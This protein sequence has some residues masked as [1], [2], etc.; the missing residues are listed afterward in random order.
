MGA[1]VTHFEIISRNGEQL[2]QFYARLFGWK[3]SSDNPIR[4]GLV[5]KEGAGIGGGIASPGPDG[6]T[7]VTIYAVVKDPQATLDQA[8]AMG[9][10]VVLPVTQIPG[11]VTYALFTDPDGNRIGIVKDEPMPRTRRPAKKAKRTP[12]K[13]S[14]RSGKSGSSRKLRYH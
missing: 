2:Q 6:M 13:K 7:H 11:M 4:Y 1:P 3:I 8:V 12:K 10:A 5:K 9:G 14:G